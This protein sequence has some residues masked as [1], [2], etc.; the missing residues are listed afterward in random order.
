LAD[1]LASVAVAEG[2]LPPVLNIASPRAI[3]MQAIAEGAE[4]PWRWR[5]APPSAHQIIVLDCSAVQVIHSF[6]PDDNS[7]ALMLAR[8]HQVRPRT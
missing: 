4:I 1:V 8:L 2:P 6:E 3:S 7:P 5:P